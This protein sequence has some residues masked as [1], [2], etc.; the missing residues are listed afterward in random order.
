MN[1]GN[2][3]Q[4][5]AEITS[6]MKYYMKWQQSSWACRHFDS[7][8][9]QPPAIF[10]LFF[11]YLLHLPHMSDNIKTCCSSKVSLIKS[12]HISADKTANVKMVKKQT[13]LSIALIFYVEW[14]TEDALLMLIFVFLV[15][16]H[17]GSQ[18][19]QCIKSRNWLD[20]HRREVGIW[21]I[22]VCVLN[23][24]YFVTIKLQTSITTA[25][26]EKEELLKIY[27]FCTN[28]F[29]TNAVACCDLAMI[30]DTQNNGVAFFWKGTP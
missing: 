22:V 13:F 29:Q 7:S 26:Y 19:N 23:C 20:K 6:E 2:G 15:S 8:T 10:S 27:N 1:R 3:R 25:F 4:Y 21:N 9:E 12:T 16:Y 5:T 28:W 14:W 18:G 30:H 24:D 11:L 17:L